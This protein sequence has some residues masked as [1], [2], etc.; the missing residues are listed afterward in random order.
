MNLY[1]HIFI[2]HL[3]IKRNLQRIIQVIFTWTLISLG[4]SKQFTQYSY[5]YCQV[6]KSRWCNGRATA[7]GDLQHVRHIIPRAIMRRGAQPHHVTHQLVQLY[8]FQG[9][10]LETTLEIWS[11]V[12]NSKAI[13]IHRPTYK[14][15]V[16]VQEYPP[17]I[18]VRWNVTMMAQRVCFSWF[19]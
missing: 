9:R 12:Y 14:H 8:V 3:Y 15:T 11:K 19:L 6:C 7:D 17:Y 16:Q 2:Y 18:N 1:C 5:H 13:L 10:L 4:V